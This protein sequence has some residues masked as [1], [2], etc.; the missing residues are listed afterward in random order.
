MLRWRI[1]GG[2][3]HTCTQR[4]RSV[5]AVQLLAR[6]AASNGSGAAH[7]RAAR[8]PTRRRRL[9]PCPPS[10]PSLHAARD[11][12]A[13]RLLEALG[14]GDGGE[15]DDQV[16]AHLAP[17]VR[18]AAELL[19]ASRDWPLLE[20]ALREAAA[21]AGAGGTAAAERA[22]AAAAVFVAAGIGSLGQYRARLRRE[23]QEEQ[24]AEAQQRDARR[25]ACPRAGMR[26]FQLALACL[27]LS[28]RA[29]SSAAVAVAADPEYDPVDRCLLE[30][31]GFSRALSGTA[32]DA[33]RAA[34][35]AAA[36]VEEAG[37][38]SSS[39]L[40]YMPLCPRDAYDEVL[41]AFW[42]ADR[43]P[44]L[45]LLG[46]SLGSQGESSALVAALAALGGGGGNRGLASPSSAANTPGD[47]RPSEK[48]AQ[49]AGAAAEAAGVMI[50]LPSPDFA[51]HGVGVALH[52]FTREGSAK[53]FSASSS[54]SSS[55][56][57][58]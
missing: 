32:A 52:A 51:C 30:S 15:S 8:A 39:C 38:P 45:Q 48:Q 33:L 12:L 44:L 41:S 35:A 29:S 49:L 25:R 53:F 31:L 4:R 18:E 19:R 46:T 7:A 14:S 26:L 58:V 16:A 5:R 3:S 22:P 23:V 6:A 50:E 36:A 11:A 37:A 27:L 47:D 21:A 2:T 17:L 57:S 24:A 40:C 1:P 13:D 54:S 55:S 34:A 28:E 9:P 10:P 43:L 42:S 20:A 56:S